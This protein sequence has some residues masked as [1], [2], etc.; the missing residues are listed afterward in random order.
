MLAEDVERLAKDRRFLTEE[1]FVCDEKKIAAFESAAIPFGRVLRTLRPRAADCIR[2]AASVL[3]ACI[4]AS[5][6]IDRNWCSLDR[7]SATPRAM[8]PR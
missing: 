6:S 4:W 5:S 2:I 1:L 3:L 8:R 7:A